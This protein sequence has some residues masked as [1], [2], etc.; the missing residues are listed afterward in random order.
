MLREC[1]LSVAA[2]Q[3]DQVLVVDDGSEGY[4]VARVVA[5]ALYQRVEYG[6]VTAP[7][8]TVAARMVTPRQGR[9]INEALGYVTGDVACSICDDD[10]MA[11]GWLD[12]LR[13]HWDAHPDDGLVRGDWLVFQDGAAPG[14][15]D[16]PCPLDARGMT[17]GNFAWHMRLVHERGVRWPEAVLHCLDNGF[18]V[19]C[20]NAGA[21][22]YDAPHI[23]ALA[24]WRRDHPKVCVK[25]LDAG[26]YSEEFKAVLESGVLE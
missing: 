13:A 1:L 6:L 22:M 26:Q 19:N 24:G 8:L 17:A 2:A 14:L 10:L 12:A 18:L 25:H 20:H 9:L 7:P 5:F 3:P 4:S 15:D 16:A 21:M 11:V 23:G